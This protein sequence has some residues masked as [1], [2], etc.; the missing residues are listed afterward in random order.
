MLEDKRISPKPALK[1]GLTSTLLQLLNSSTEPVH[2]QCVTAVI[3]R[4]ARE[5][6]CKEDML[7]HGV[8]PALVTKLLA[9][10]YD[11]DVAIIAARAM[12]RLCTTTVDNYLLNL[13]LYNV[14]SATLL[15]SKLFQAHG[16]GSA[17]KYATRAMYNMALC[18]ARPVQKEFLSLI[19]R[20]PIYEVM[21][22]VLSR[23]TCEDTAEHVMRCLALLAS[24]GLANE[25][26][27]RGALSAVMQSLQAVRFNSSALYDD[28]A[29]RLLLEQ[30]AGFQVDV[31]RI[32][33]VFS[34]KAAKAVLKLGRIVEG[35]SKCSEGDKLYV[36]VKLGQKLGSD[37]ST[38][39]ALTELLD[40]EA[41]GFLLAALISRPEGDWAAARHLLAGIEVLLLAARRSSNPRHA[42]LT[43]LHGPAGAEEITNLTRY[44]DISSIRDEDYTAVVRLAKSIQDGCFADIL[45]GASL[46]TAQALPTWTNDSAALDGEEEGGVDA[47]AWGSSI[48]GVKEEAVGEQGDA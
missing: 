27:T 12:A 8:L 22:D 14:K 44:H 5:K 47:P 36:A 10:D 1:K 23:T 2:L 48:A 45:P 38:E 15:F 11:S 26:L 19:F 41:V 16:R 46:L 7:N 30:P 24:S 34:S 20:S 9:L 32:A 3:G 42:L 37:S 13:S 33:D 6:A 31:K 28:A 39:E 18:L 17:L 29:R 35:Y 43:L 25:M 4:L 40:S 21:V